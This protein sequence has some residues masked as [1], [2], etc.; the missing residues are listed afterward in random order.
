MNEPIRDHG[1]KVISLVATI[2]MNGLMF[3]SILL[4]GMTQQ[5][6]PEPVNVIPVDMVELAR[7]SETPV[8]KKRLPRLTQPTPPK[9]P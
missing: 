1:T 5:E 4:M 8:D 2:G 6:A 9:S 7:K 3:A